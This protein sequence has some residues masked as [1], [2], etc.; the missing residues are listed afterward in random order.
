M[1]G[2]ACVLSAA[3]LL[4]G[5]ANI[6]EG[7]QKASPLPQDGLDAYG[8]TGFV[9]EP[10]LAATPLGS[11]LR[12]TLT[13]GATLRAGLAGEAAAT[14]RV[15]D[16]RS[17]Y[18]P[19]IGLGVTAGTG[20]GTSDGL[21]P[22][23]RVSQRLFDGSASARRVA[24]AENRVATAAAETEQRL[25][26]R[27]LSA[28]EA[29]EELHTARRIATIA[30]ASLARSDE[31]AEQ[32]RRRFDAGAGRTAD[33]LRTQSRQAEARAILASAE[34]RVAEARTRVT[35]LFG[36]LPSSG[37]LP[38]A[39]PPVSPGEANAALKALRWELEAAR[40]DLDA[41]RAERAPTVFL[42][43][44]GSLDDDNSPEMGAAI[45][46]DYALGTGGQRKAAVRSAEAEVA[47]IKAELALL[48]S[49]L[50]RAIS[51][52]EARE[53][54]LATEREAARTAEQTAASALED[55]ER[56]FES[57]RV[58]SLDLLDLGTDLD[59]AATRHAEIAAAHRLVGYER[60]AISGE[61]LAVFGIDVQSI[62]P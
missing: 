58:D 50:D 10:V 41:R 59:R 33:V 14:A 57:G 23:L 25:A 36:A 13:D 48:E 55:A 39:P 18:R 26:D 34:G 53:R 21:S 7:A 42:D 8:E 5:C 9:R 60:L 29:W 40:A 51:A 56:G 19:S 12:G 45:R 31:L 2:R 22:A 28:I 6:G 17:A 35:E 52:V 43:V 49:D 20:A 38:P 15:A 44:L 54:A 1:I 27:A 16:A 11:A 32:V 47:R 3:L 4:A 46:L 30:L 61:L 62:R 24:A 37:P